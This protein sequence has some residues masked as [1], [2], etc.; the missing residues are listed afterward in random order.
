MWT[1]P[2]AEPSGSTQPDGAQARRGPTVTGAGRVAWSV[3]RIVSAPAVKRLLLAW[4][5]PLALFIL[6]SV[7]AQHE[8]IAAQILPSPATVASTFFDLMQSGELQRHLAISLMRVLAG[9][10]GGIAA[11]L[12][13]G[14]AMGLSPLTR[15][16]LYPTFKAFAQVPSL[17]WLP[18]LMMVLGI[19]EALK[20][21]LIAK[22][23]LVPV[24]LNTYKGIENVPQGLIEIAQVYRFKRHQLLAKVI[25]PAAFPPIWAGVRY[26]LT[27]AWLG[28]VAVELL[29][30]SE[31]LG[32]LIVYGRQL[33]Q[34]DVVMAAVVV[35]GAVGFA[36]DRTLALIEA[37][38][39]HW[40]R[41]NA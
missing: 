6:W 11:G 39:L 1:L 7:T 15:D 20:I 34:M 12:V 26:G 9:C 27:H 30:S 8:W 17:G 21:A 38:V 19:G 2:L 33:Y 14:G 35:V 22:A 18:L 23:C 10:F 28:L 31:G 4:P 32:F 24:A 41:R 36:L 3:R 16:Y 13:L 40:R 5:F 29:A 25:F 37:R